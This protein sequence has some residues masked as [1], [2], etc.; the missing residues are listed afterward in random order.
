MKGLIIVNAYTYMPNNEYQAQRIKREL[1]TRGVE[2]EIIRN[3]SFIARIDGSGNISA[4]SGYDFAVYLDK[5]KYISSMLELS[6]LRLFNSHASIRI[7]DD[8]AA[9]Y[10][11]LSGSGIAVP[12]TL[13][14]LLCYDKSA[15]VNQ[16]SLDIVENSLGYPL[17]IKECYGSLGKGVYKADSREQ[18]EQYAAKLITTPHLF[19]QYIESSAGTDMR[20]IVVGGKCIAAMRRVSKSDFRSNIELGGR[21]E[22]YNLSEKTIEICERAASILG[23]DYCGIDMLI[24]SSGEP[25]IL[26]E[27]NSNAFFTAIEKITGVNIAAAYAEHIVKEMNARG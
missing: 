19:Q 10:I 7:C 1:E 23:L 5:D 11:A 16:T 24:G 17:I 22:P 26:C 13:T 4:V 25:E 3:D 2:T 18:L 6:G 20:V 14:G 12:R 21:G 9:T 15:C 8:K 27:V